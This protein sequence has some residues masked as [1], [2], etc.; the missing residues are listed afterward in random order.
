MSGWS[1]HEGLAICLPL[2]NIDTD[3]LIPA[4]FMSRPRSEGYGD[5]LLHDLRRNTD[6]KPDA[7][8]VFNK[9]PEASVLVAGQNFG[10]GSSREA[11]VYALVDAG[12]RAVIAPSFADIF[13]AN[14]VNNGLLPACI[15]ETDVSSLFDL[16]G[17]GTLAMRI[18]LI[19]RSVEIVS[20]TIG[21]NVFNERALEFNIN[22]NASEKLLNG[23]DDIDLT[24]KHQ[25]QITAFREQ[26]YQQH[27]WAW[28]ISNDNDA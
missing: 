7:D 27:S 25:T 24:L 2:N 20:D 8:F 23:W 19:Q 13:F 26:R 11:A 22:E 14:A 15:D 9:H 17:E 12:I 10:S 3:Q 5:F 18:N 16:I 21:S 4:R 1:Q 28:P 6:G